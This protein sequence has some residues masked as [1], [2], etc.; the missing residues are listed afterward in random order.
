M[1]ELRV[2][3]NFWCFLTM[4]EE[5]Q[6]PGSEDQA[7]QIAQLQGQVAELTE[8][9]K[10]ARSMAMAAITV[11]FRASKYYQYAMPHQ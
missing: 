3:S 1:L 7:S 8:A 11:W 10:N 4:Q 2:P 5:D 6:V 9:L